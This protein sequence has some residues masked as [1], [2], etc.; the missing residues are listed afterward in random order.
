M[1]FYKHVIAMLFS[2]LLL[3][4]CGVNASLQPAEQAFPAGQQGEPTPT[5]LQAALAVEPTPVPVDECVACH[6]D[7]QRLTDT[8]KPEEAGEFESKGV[9]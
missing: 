2:A 4:A 7:Q 5:A 6:V 9:G 3:T 1:S 8:A